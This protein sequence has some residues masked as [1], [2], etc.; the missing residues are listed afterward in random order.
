MSRLDEL[1]KQYPELNVTVFD[2][3]KAMDPTSSYKYFPL[4]CKIFSKRWRIDEQYPKDEVSK[5]M[6]EYRTLLTNL[7]IN[8]KNLNENQI[9]FLRLL[10]DF[11]PNNHFETMREF[12]TLMEN[13]RLENKDV[14]S[15]GSL[16][17]IRK[18]VS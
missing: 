7:G 9:Y 13:K 12:I 18:A 5:V 3:F 11:Y 4:L 6:M 17:D 14:T 10:M 15:Y 8:I 16:D 2:L 1:K